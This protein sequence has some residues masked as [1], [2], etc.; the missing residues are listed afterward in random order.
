MLRFSL[1]S[2]SETKLN[3]SSLVRDQ[4]IAMNLDMQTALIP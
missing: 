4:S 2:K 1:R 3:P